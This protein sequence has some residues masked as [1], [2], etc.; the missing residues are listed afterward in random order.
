M[1]VVTLSYADRIKPTDKSIYSYLDDLLLKNYQ[2]PTFQREV[3]WEK[4][5]VKK[6]WDSIYKFYP[7]GSILIWKTDIQLQN[8]REIGGHI[9]N[10]DFNRVEYQYILDGQQRTTSLLTSIYGGRIE[11]KKDFDPALY[12]DLT[13]MDIDET[14]D[15]S[16]KRRFL[17]WDEIDDNNGRIK[18]NTQRKLKFEQGLIVKLKKIREHFGD[19][20]RSL[21]N[22]TDEDYKDY[23][24]P[25]RV[26]LRKI[27]EVLDSYRISLIE[28]KGIQV[29][30][31][32]QIFERINQSGKPLDIFDIVVAKTFRPTNSTVKGF[33]L[34]E[35]V[36][37]F[38]SIN[39]SNYMQIDDLTY[40]QIL[41]VIINKKI[42]NSGVLNITD[43]YL[44]NI[45]AE[46]VETIWEKA[47][48][49]ILK[50]FDF[51]ENHLRIKGP[52]LIPFRYF[53]MTLAFYFYGNKKPDYNFINKYF[54][55][56]SFHNDDLLSN[57]TQLWRHIDFLEKQKSGESVEFDRFLIDKNSLRSSSYSSKGRLSRA[58]LS[59]YASRDPRDWENTNRSVLSDVYYILTDKP[60]LHHIFPINY[61]NNNKGRNR[62]DSNSLMNIA[63]LTQITNLHISDKNPLEYIQEFN[64]ED[65]NNVLHSHYISTSILDWVEMEEMPDTA[66]DIF[67]NERIEN[68]I[69]DLRIK[70]ADIKF[71]VVDTVE[72]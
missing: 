46:Q 42:K 54:W 1:E 34:R 56:Y 60:N 19:V 71:E 66:L 50:T 36:N 39:Q 69:D 25:I 67:I 17:F 41:S 59:L 28:L 37:D 65:F 70:L 10:D 12:F 49:S 14:D 8:H 16:Y 64:K 7:L 53:Y 31:V 63:Y 22:N 40:L 33:Y 3:V 15:E 32:C 38:R 2:I 52:Q 18:A 11:G 20:E 58:I 51:F 62:Y 30:E 29:S 57:T 13:V 61:I 6:L 5:N 26:Q 35:L 45:R 24:N 23:D 43:K 48:L 68:I 55:Y 44:N 21:V 27:K 9:I 4:E 72:I 47:K